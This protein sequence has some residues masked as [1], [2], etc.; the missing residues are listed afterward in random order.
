[1]NA[2][3]LKGNW[4]QIKGTVRERWDKLSD[5][6]LDEISGREEK[7]IGKIQEKY[8][9]AKLEAKKA[10]VDFKLKQARRKTEK[11]NE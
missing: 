3:W 7:L 2:D 6:D 9:I 5:V 10:V 11:R 8:G 1:M 4:K